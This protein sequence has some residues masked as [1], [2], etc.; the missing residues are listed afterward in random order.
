MASQSSSSAVASIQ[1]VLNFKEVLEKEIAKSSNDTIDVERCNDILEQLQPN[2]MKMKYAILN[3]TLIGVTVNKLKTNATLQP[4]VKALIKA[5]KQ[6]ANES[7]PSSNET[8]PKIKPSPPSLSVSSRTKSDTNSN[9]SIKKEDTTKKAEDIDDHDD[10]EDDDMAVT[11]IDP[12]TAFAHLNETPRISFCQKLFLIFQKQE[13]QLIQEAQYHPSTIPTLLY[14]CCIDMER[15]IYNAYYTRKQHDK[16]GYADKARSLL[17]N[18]NKNRTLTMSLLMGSVPCSDVVQYTTEQLANEQM[19]LLRKETTQKLI[20]SKRLDW[21][22]AN[23]DKINNMCG[24]SGDLLNAS[25]FTCGRCKSIKTTS[26]QKQ[27]RSADEPMT[28]FVLC[29]NCGKRWKC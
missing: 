26:T 15:A 27:T 1:A 14:N 3:E 11:P 2:Q 6:I 10:D 12:S 22:E 13:S 7:H 29:L 21:N 17:F 23:E 8:T 18:L 19:Q 20:D 4:K 24:I 25:L 28:V 9:N 16:K 5:W